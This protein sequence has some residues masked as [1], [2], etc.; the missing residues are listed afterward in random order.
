M[1]GTQ[2]TPILLAIEQTLYEQRA[3]NP[4]L[5]PKY[6]DEAITAAAKIMSDVI[7]SHMWELQEA[8]K[9]SQ[10]DRENMAVACG[11]ELRLL[12][13]KYTGKDTREIIARTRA[14]TQY[15]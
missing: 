6:P 10:V 3:L 13:R 7:M 2:I 12:I 5:H 9:I 11:N 15:K 4:N 14:R 8:E 1:I